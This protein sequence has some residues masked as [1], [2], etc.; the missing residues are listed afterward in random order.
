MKGGAQRHDPDDG[1]REDGCVTSDISRSLWGWQQERRMADWAAIV[2]LE[3][4]GQSW[5]IR[6]CVEKGQSVSVN[7]EGRESERQRRR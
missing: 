5:R 7:S 1:A 3:V 2:S 6:L 4:T